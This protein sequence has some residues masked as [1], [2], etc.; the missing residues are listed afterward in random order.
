MLTH[1]RSWRT[2]GLVAPILLAVGVSVGASC[3]PDVDLPVV[4]ECGSV[5]PGVRSTVDVVHG[6]WRSRPFFPRVLGNAFGQTVSASETTGGV[7]DQEQNSHAYFNRLIGSAEVFCGYSLRSQAELD[8][9]TRR[10]VSPDV[11]YDSAMD[12]ARVT[13]PPGD[14]RD[15]GIRRQVRLP[16]GLSS[17]TAVVTWDVRWSDSYVNAVESVDDNKF[18][19][20][21]FQLGV[22]SGEDEFEA[23]R[24]LEPKARYSKASGGDVAR[25]DARAYG[26]L[27]PPYTMS[28]GRIEPI[29]QNWYA[30]PE[31]WTRYWVLVDLDDPTYTRMSMWVA[32]E[33]RDAVQLYNAVGMK[34]IASL[35]NFW[36]EYASSQKRT[37][38]PELVSHVRNLVVLK[39]VS[40]PQG[41][42]EKPLS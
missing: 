11:V 21:Q 7:P 8:R 12:A 29:E 20:K 34:K 19:H 36:I 40:E 33:D 2:L 28:D 27:E 32:D 38:G 16:I 23:D 35:H 26:E 3:E 31:T 22:P 5:P 41:L 42:L 4:G 18:N 9:H 10:G 30:K 15:V 17:G 25:V 37:G 6:R 39:D 14:G 1:G 13:I 24:W